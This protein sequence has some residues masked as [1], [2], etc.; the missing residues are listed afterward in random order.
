MGQDFL[1]MLH[2]TF[3]GGVVNENVIDVCDY[4]LPQ[5]ISQHI[6]QTLEHGGGSRETI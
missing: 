4:E 6:N 2:L 5:H 3:K 1:D